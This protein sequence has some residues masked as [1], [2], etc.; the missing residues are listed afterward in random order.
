MGMSY[1]LDTHILLW[2]LFDDPKLDINY[3]EIIYNLDNQIFVS[4]A[5]AWE[6]EPVL[7][8]A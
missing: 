8:T 6:A 5:S 3:R 7:P 1:L 4:S 2:W